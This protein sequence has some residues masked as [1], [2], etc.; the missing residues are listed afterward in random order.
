M[1]RRDEKYAAARAK[2]FTTD[3][4]RAYLRELSIDELPGLTTPETT[5][6]MLVALRS[7]RDEDPFRRAGVR[8][9]E[10]HAVSRQRRAAR[11]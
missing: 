4:G 9:P 1:K 10:E 11:R 3:V 8:L 2:L 6:I 5:A 7:A